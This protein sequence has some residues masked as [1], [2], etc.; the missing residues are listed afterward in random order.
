[1]KFNTA[2]TLH[3]NRLTLRPHKENDLDDCVAL[4]NDPIVTQHTSGTTISRQYVWTR[5][6]VTGHYWALATG[7]FVSVFLESS[8]AK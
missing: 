5:I 2:P 7:L 4:W 3:T 8:W 1:M 6:L